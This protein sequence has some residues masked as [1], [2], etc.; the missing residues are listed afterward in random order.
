MSLWLSTNPAGE[1]KGEKDEAAS[2][3]FMHQCAPFL[4]VVV[5]GVVWTIVDGRSKKRKRPPP[6]PF[7]SVI[8]KIKKKN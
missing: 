7:L 2:P 5:A 1:R 3:W 4:F 6:H 8:K